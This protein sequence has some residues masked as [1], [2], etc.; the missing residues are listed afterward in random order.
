M[1]GLEL[2]YPYKSK[3]VDRFIM[4]TEDINHVI[5]EKDISR[6]N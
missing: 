2:N 1:E 4:K 5:H 3:I 6:N